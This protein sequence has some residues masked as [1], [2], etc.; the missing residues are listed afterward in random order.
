MFFNEVYKRKR[1]ID[2]RQNLSYEINFRKQ[3]LNAFVKL[4][5]PAL[6]FPSFEKFTYHF[7]SSFQ[8]KFKNQIGY[9]VQ[10]LNGQQYQF[11]RQQRNEDFLFAFR[12]CY[13]QFAASFFSVLSLY[14]I[15]CPINLPC[16]CFAMKL[17]PNRM[18]S[19]EVRRQS[20]P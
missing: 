13:F 3:C 17:P 12:K 14:N 1:H 19:A 15:R 7:L 5:L 2:N 4:R 8:N 10:A 6:F 9:D 11:Y 16:A 20:M 18:H